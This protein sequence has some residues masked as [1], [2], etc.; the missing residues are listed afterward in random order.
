MV[1]ALRLQGF[2]VFGSL[3]IEVCGSEG[4]DASRKKLAL[5]L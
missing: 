2:E 1:K 3:G 4:S 5:K